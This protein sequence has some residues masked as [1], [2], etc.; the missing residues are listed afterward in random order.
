MIVL[1]VLLLFLAVV[2]LSL[3]LIKKPANWKESTVVKA[4]LIFIEIV[5]EEEPDW[6][7]SNVYYYPVL[8]Y[9]YDFNGR[10]YKGVLDRSSKSLYRIPEEIISKDVKRNEKISWKNLEV[11]DEI[12]LLINSKKP[13]QHRVNMDIQRE[14]KSG[15]VVSL[16][17]SV[18]FGALSLLVFLI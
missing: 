15:Y 5:K 7:S 8:R 14:L 13:S 4:K 12:E 11:G 10:K 2:F 17:L 16:V 6:I 1:G 3:Y 9:E 18:L